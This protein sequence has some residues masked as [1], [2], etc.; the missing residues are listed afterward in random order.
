MLAQHTPAP[1]KGIVRSKFLDKMYKQW[2]LEIGRWSAY[3]PDSVIIDQIKNDRNLLLYAV[4]FK[5]VPID[6]H[7][8]CKSF[9]SNIRPESRLKVEARAPLNTLQQ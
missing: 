7:A 1:L 4:N 5:G 9:F 8:G 3:L 2:F 6:T